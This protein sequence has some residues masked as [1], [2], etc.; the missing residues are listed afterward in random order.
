MEENAP[1]AMY[2]G[3]LRIGS[4]EINC[5][6]LENQERIL[7]TR[8]MMKALGRTWRGRKYS[9][10]ELPVF[11]EAK[12]LKPF[13]DSDL[14]AVLSVVEFRTP[15]GN[16]A[17]GFKAELLPSICELYLKAR[18]KGALTVAQEGV[19]QRAEILM[20]GLAH[21]GIIAMIDEATG[22]Q[23]HR[24][25]DALAKILEAFI[26]KELVKWVKTFPD[27]FYEKLFK[28]K[29]WSFNP[30]SVKKPIYVGR[31]TNDLV[32]E[33]LAP[34]V[35]EELKRL[36][37]KTEKGT[38][39]HRHHQWLTQEIGHPKLKEHLASLV[40]LMRASANWGEFHRMVQ[41]ALP[42]YGDL[43]LLDY[44]EK[45]AKLKEIENDQGVKT[46]PK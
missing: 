35:L 21:V 27:E 33:R 20:R 28:L 22:F 11:V 31:L 3:V 18:D 24:V 32:Y 19:A 13:I 34:G 25:K 12:N 9:G 37:P 16:K 40:T 43:P 10:T 5:Y 23:A 26:S 41:R 8:G 15:Q 1:R 6:V 17:E 14:S 42:K 45:Q 4:L 36:N 7:S 30:S 2:E 38:R 39:R 44:A 46:E 29:G